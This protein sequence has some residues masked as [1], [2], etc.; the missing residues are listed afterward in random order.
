M[1]MGLVGEHSCTAAVLITHRYWQCNSLAESAR[2]AALLSIA[3]G[4]ALE[5]S[6]SEESAMKSQDPHWTEPEPQACNNCLG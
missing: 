2:R 6:Y 1:L 4:V 5:I 3:V